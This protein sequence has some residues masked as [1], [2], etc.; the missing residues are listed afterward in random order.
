MSID[1]VS[2]PGINRV[3]TENKERIYDKD[4]FSLRAS[5]IIW[6]SKNQNKTLLIKNKKGN[7]CV[8]GGAVEE[9]DKTILKSAI[10]EVEEEAG[11][12]GDIINYIGNFK[13]YQG[14][15]KHN[16]FVWNIVVSSE[17]NE[18]KENYRERKWF[19]IK[20][21]LQFLEH[22]PIQK[23]MLLNSKKNYEH[24]VNKK[25]EDGFISFKKSYRDWYLKNNY[26]VT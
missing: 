12:K 4:G 10:R 26:L 2:I 21:A 17:L 20:E 9:K 19:T 14:K 11:I 13:D 24:S 5:C 22:K 1:I 6:D 18:Y 25:I 3:I 16:I 23:E 8:P 15:N 7:W